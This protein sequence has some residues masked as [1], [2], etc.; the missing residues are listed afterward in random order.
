MRDV[1]YVGPA[2]VRIL[3][4]AD[5]AKM[6]LEH[7]DTMEFVRGIRQTVS[8]KMAEHLLTH[9]IIIGEFMELDPEESVE[10]ITDSDGEGDP[11][12]SDGDGGDDTDPDDTSGNDAD[13]NAGET[14]DDDATAASEKADGHP[15]DA[16]ASSGSRP[17]SGNRRSAS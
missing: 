13:P 12:G 4:E 2:N 6:G 9:H 8:N 7:K 15:Q 14:V 10:L 3:A 16:A 5:F 11:E 1:I 17:R